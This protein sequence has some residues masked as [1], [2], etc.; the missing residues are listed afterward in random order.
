MIPRRMWSAAALAAWS[1]AAGCVLA[2]GA[3][4]VVYAL[5]GRVVDA[6]THR[7]IARALV[8]SGDRRLATMTD[9][10]GNFAIDVSIPAATDTQAGPS[11]DRSLRGGILP[12]FNVG[13]MARRPG[14]LDRFEQTSVALT[15]A[16]TEA[17]IVLEL[18]PAATISGVVMGEGATGAARVQLTLL[19]HQVQDGAL[20]WRQRASAQSDEEGTFRFGDL[21]P[22]EYT[23]L[24]QE[25]PGDDPSYTQV[26]RQFPPR[27]LGDVRNLTAATKLKLRPGEGEKVVLHLRPATYFPVKVPV[28]GLPP[29]TPVQGRVISES[30][31]TGYSLG[32]NLRDQ[33]VEG[34]LPGG[35]YTLMLESFGPQ[36]SSA[37]LPLVVGT[38]SLEHAPLALAANG[39]IPVRV[40]LNLTGKEDSG[41]RG[42]AYAGNVDAAPT[43]ASPVQMSLR[44]ADP[45]GAQGGILRHGEG[46]DSVLENVGP[47]TYTLEASTIRGYIASITSGGV[48]LLRKPLVVGDGGRA[49]PIDV[50]VRDDG[51]VVTGD[52]DFAGKEGSQF[53]VVALVESDG[54]QVHQGFFQAGTKFSI[55]NVPPGTYR[56]FAVDARQAQTLP[57]RDEAAMR[58]YNPLGTAVT[59]SANG[60]ADVK[61][62][63]VQL[64]Q[65]GTK[66]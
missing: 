60:Q 41:P 30:T 15:K 38:A 3:A 53:C 5:H 11:Y 56:A 62:R 9:H 2:Q 16:G 55:S 13:F 27:Y 58:L 45:Q 61:L 12:T 46:S 8:Y 40:H 18:T 50:V 25:W 35:D 10:N 23:V 34:A 63:F 51:A 65:V 6:L 37:R 21:T 33:A 29:N 42:F 43:A 64:E 19:E 22:G 28:Q 36:H 1:A 14:Y 32:W 31:A 17:D 7:P 52:V 48:D 47:G 66:E 44:S 4:D 57:Y 20:V 26:S 39:T 24:S 54:G 49:D 59:V